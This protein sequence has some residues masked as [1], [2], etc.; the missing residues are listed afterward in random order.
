M[1]GCR[2]FILSH[3]TTP[4]ADP[5][6]GESRQCLTPLAVEGRVPATRNRAPTAAIT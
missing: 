5:G 3:N 4:P 6:G 1:D 2:R